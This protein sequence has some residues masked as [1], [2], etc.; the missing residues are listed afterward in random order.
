MV[1]AKEQKDQRNRKE[2]PEIDPYKYSQLIFDKGTKAIQWRIVFS[3][4]ADGTTGSLQAK[5]ESRYT[6]YLSPQKTTQNGPQV[7]M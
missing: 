2:S 5:N 1:L 4:D 3:T 6:W 7:Y